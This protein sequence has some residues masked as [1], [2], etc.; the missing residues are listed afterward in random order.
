MVLD[1]GGVAEQGTHS[2]LMAA[3]GLYSRLVRIQQQSLDWNL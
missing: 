3:G 1:G 2:E